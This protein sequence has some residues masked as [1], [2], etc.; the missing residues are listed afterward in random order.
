MPAIAPNIPE[1]SC[2]VAIIHPTN[3]PLTT[4]AESP[5]AC[6]RE[7]V[8]GST[9]QTYSPTAA[10]AETIP[11]MPPRTS[12]TAATGVKV[13]SP[14]TKPRPRASKRAVTPPRVLPGCA[15]RIDEHSRVGPYQLWPPCMRCFPYPRSPSRLPRGSLTYRARRTHENRRHDQD[16]VQQRRHASNHLTAPV[17]KFVGHL[18]NLCS[19]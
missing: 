12:I 6:V 7:G 19:R 16:G 5:M 11:Q 4:R 17:V 9:S 10:T 15:R 1:P 18:L 14:E 2:I 3:A 8:F 13:R